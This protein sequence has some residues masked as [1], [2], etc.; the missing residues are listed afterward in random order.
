MK[1][2]VCI[3]RTLFY[4]FSEVVVD[5]FVTFRNIPMKGTHLSINDKFRNIEREA[6][7]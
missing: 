2:R 6:N 3:S 7:I 5:F 4:L 1:E